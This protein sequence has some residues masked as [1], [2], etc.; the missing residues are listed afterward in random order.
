MKTITQKLQ[1]LFIC[2]ALFLFSSA[3]NAQTLTS[4]H[5]DY[6]P[7]DTAILS[8]CGF[9]PGETVIMQ[10]V[11]ADGSPST[12]DAPWSIAADANG[13]FSTGWI[14]PADAYQQL[15]LATADGQSSGLHAETTFT[16]AGTFDTIDFQQAANQN[17]PASALS[18]ICL[19]YT[20]D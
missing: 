2:S 13:C 15:L 6:S 10:V 8:G 17:H 16:D 3:V 18:W 4:D 7:G 14:V 11:R 19:L 1:L 5:L 12:G 20:S 9:Q